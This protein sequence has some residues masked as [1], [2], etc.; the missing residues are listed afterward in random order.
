VILWHRFVIAERLQGK[1]PSA[2]NAKRLAVKRRPA[3]KRLGDRQTH[4]CHLST[5]CM[6]IAEPQW[7]NQSQLDF[8]VGQD[9]VSHLLAVRAG[10]RF[11]IVRYSCVAGELA[12]GRA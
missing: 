8:L 6:L 5:S 10:Y 3:S 1:M 12:G 9:E 7:P 4:S 11:R 2:R